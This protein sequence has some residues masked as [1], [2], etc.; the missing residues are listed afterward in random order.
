MSREQRCQA[1]M[2]EGSSHIIVVRNYII[3]DDM[4]VSHVCH[5]T[6]TGIHSKATGRA[7]FCSQYMPS[8]MT[9]VF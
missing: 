2:G 6:N 3:I 1:L 5:S 4:E 7:T 9:D 8:W